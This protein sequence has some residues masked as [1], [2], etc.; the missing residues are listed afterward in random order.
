MK[1]FNLE[2][3]KAGKPVQTRDGRDARIICFDAK[4]TSCIISLIKQDHCDREDIVTH[5]IDGSWAGAKESCHDLMM[6]SEK[7]EVKAGWV[8]VLAGGN[9]CFIYDTEEEAKTN[10]ET[11]PNFVAVAKIEWEE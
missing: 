7:K 10:G 3:A 9:A 6:K 8:A 4:G 1:P 2:E 11:Y 5:W